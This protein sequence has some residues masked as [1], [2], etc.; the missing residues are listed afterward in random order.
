M[1][2]QMWWNWEHTQVGWGIQPLL[3]SAEQITLLRAFH[4]PPAKQITLAGP[5]SP[6]PGELH[7]VR[8]WEMCADCSRWCSRVT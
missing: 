6:S 8:A 4:P 2:A 3:P 7:Q 5:G 1:R